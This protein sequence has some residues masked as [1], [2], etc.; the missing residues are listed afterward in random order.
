LTIFEEEIDYD[1]L[2]NMIKKFNIDINV[3]LKENSEIIKNE[4]KN[5]KNLE[6]CHYF[7]DSFSLCLLAFD[8]AKDKKYEIQIEFN[9]DTDYF[10][11]KLKKLFIQKDYD[12]ASIPWAK[13]LKKISF[14]TFCI[15]LCLIVIIILFYCIKKSI[16]RR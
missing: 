1:I 7:G 8:S 6:C 12:F 14:V 5:Q 9:I 15:C 11:G 13:D 16:K 4:L 2:F 3:N 10:N